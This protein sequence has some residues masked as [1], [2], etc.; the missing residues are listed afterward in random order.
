MSRA[1][2]YTRVS[3]EEQVSNRSLDTQLKECEAYCDRE[4]LDVV[5]VFTDEGV[6]AK[7]ANR[8]ALQAMIDFVGHNAA[9]LGIEVVV[10]YRVDRFARNQLDHQ[11]VRALL[12]S[13][14]VA[15]RSVTEPID[16]S[17]SGN[18]M[19]NVLAAVAQFDNDVRAARTRDGMKAALATGRW[20]QRPPLGFSKPRLRD[21]GPSLIHD[22]VSGPLVAKAFEMIATSDMTQAEV[23]GHLTAMN[24][25]TQRGKS[26]SRQTF[27]KLLR[28]P[29][30]TG[31]MLVPKLDFDGPGDFEPLVSDELFRRVQEILDGRSSRPPGARNLVTDFP[32]RRTAKCPACGGS[33]TGSFSKGRSKRYG[34]YWC[35]KAGCTGIRVAKPTL[36]NRFLELLASLA[37]R[38]EVLDLLDA[39]VADRCE[40]RRFAATTQVRELQSRID[41]VQLRED[42]LVDAHL[43]DGLIDRDTFLSQKERLAA[44]RRDL[45]AALDQVTVIDL[46]LSALM[47]FARSILS[48][49]D[50]TWEALPTEDRARFAAALFPTG[51]VIERGSIRTAEIG[52]SVGEIWDEITQPSDM[53]PPTGFEPVL[54]A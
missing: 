14:G 17:P 11:T 44:T 8:G 21:G 36:E 40:E 13:K 31:R 29:I 7:T 37:V 52:W 51:I 1:L 4:G 49:L 20:V 3:T 15:L 16:D 39:V 30:Y 35:H 41:E 34:Y 10:V 48:N 25:T 42:R 46:D 22:P 50:G 43:H 6:S 24:L 28:N 38:P 2:I 26:L 23:L 5:R 32:L 47:I 45:D 33:L 18:F 54:P 12:R 9:K 53:A 19:E 27:G